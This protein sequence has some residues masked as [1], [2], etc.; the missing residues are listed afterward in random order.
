MPPSPRM[1]ELKALRALAKALGVYTRYTDGLGRHVVVAPETL[2]R[3][4]AA[5]GAP[6]AGPGDAAGALSEHRAAGSGRALG[7][8]AAGLLS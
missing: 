3:V 4:C 8:P 2:V 1:D 6:I 5:V 7:F